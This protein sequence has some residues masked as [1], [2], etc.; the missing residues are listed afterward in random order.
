VTVK[1]STEPIDIYTCDVDITVLQPD[2]AVPDEPKDKKLA[3]VAQ[4]TKR[5]R[6][7]KD[8]LEHEI[9]MYNQFNE[10]EDLRMMKSTINPEF[11]K[12]FNDAFKLYIRGQWKKAKENLL[13]AESL[14]GA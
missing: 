8:A 13:L 11:I 14:I 1:G 2:L 6:L 9:P 10:D 7:R 5:D 4:R 3:R 12:Q